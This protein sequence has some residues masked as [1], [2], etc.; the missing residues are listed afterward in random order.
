[1]SEAI[2]HNGFPCRLFRRLETVRENAPS[3]VAILEGMAANLR[4]AGKPVGHALVVP[5]ISGAGTDVL[6]LHD[7]TQ[8][9]AEARRRATHPCSH[10]PARCRT[11][12]RT[13]CFSLAFTQHR[14]AIPRLQCVDPL[15]WHRCWRG[16]EVLDGHDTLQGNESEG[17]SDVRPGDYLVGSAK[18]LGVSNYLISKRTAPTSVE[19]FS[20]VLLNACPYCRDVR[21]SC[22]LSSTNNARRSHRL[23]RWQP[24]V[25]V[26]TRSHPS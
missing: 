4:Q 22:A 20:L 5:R 26:A 13:A 17:L 10:L 3:N 24:L 6:V 1:M 23:M 11:E 2:V 18:S 21:H 15:S 9:S 8:R 12:L 16:H 14:L 7:A 25:P 19:D